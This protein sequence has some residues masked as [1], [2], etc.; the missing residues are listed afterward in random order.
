[1]EDY[2][3]KSIFDL[4]FYSKTTFKD[5]KLLT[6]LKHN[7]DLVPSFT[8]K[9][10]EILDHFD[11]Y[12]N[13][14]YDVQGIKDKGIDVLVIYEFDNEE[15]KIGIQ[16]KSYD[17]L[18]EKDWLKT[19]K[20]QVTEVISNHRN[21]ED[22]YI[23]FCTDISKHKDK[24]RN[25][26][27][28]LAGINKIILNPE[29]S[30]YF[31]NLKDY[32]IGSYLKRKLSDDDPVVIDAKENFDELTLAQA[33]MVIE[34]ASFFMENGKKEFEHDV[35]TQSSFVSEVYDIYPNIPSELYKIADKNI[36]EL[37]RKKYEIDEISDFQSLCGKHID[38][39][40][41]TEE[42]VFD[43]ESNMALISIMYEA[44]ARLHY[45]V[46]KTKWYT[47]NL[48]KK[49]EIDTANKVKNRR[50]PTSSLTSRDTANP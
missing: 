14:T 25:A 4:F 23:A 46:S 9:L 1:M 5:T 13:I 39:L 21:I 20:A 24:I 17:D 36:K 29:H 50:L 26:T 22:F 42:F 27:A 32:E 34:V 15:K 41:N 45:D 49:S 16:I 2:I 31:M 10:N 40:S 3:K 11:R 43:H 12:H 6:H 30:L 44:R 28:E 38:M 19:L 8:N 47:I 33:A 18:E 48:L 35:I 7:K 37:F